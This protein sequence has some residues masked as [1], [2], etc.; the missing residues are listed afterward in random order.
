MLALFVSSSALG[1]ALL[2]G[3]SSTSDGWTKTGMTKEELDQDTASCLLNARA[4]V[5][6][7]EG[8]RIIVDQDRYRRCMA[9][10]GYTAGPAK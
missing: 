7:R 2:A 3:C 4:T 9:D 8:P 5:P 1:L 10:R 6:S